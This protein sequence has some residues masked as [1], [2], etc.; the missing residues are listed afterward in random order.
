MPDK[1]SES[2]L[3]KKILLLASKIG[4]R[5]F[6]NN[7]GAYEMKG[8]FWVV[9]GVASKIG[10]SD[11]IGWTPVTITDKMV[12]RKIA[13]FTAVETKIEGART[14]KDRLEKQQQFIA[15]VKRSGGIAGIV[16][17]ESELTDLLD[18]TRIEGQICGPIDN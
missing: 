2:A 18:Q 11:Y 15:I 17:S 3:G 4:S 6:R 13:V 8:G 10:G 1:I 16:K 7:C 14:K 9:F 12:G 5:I